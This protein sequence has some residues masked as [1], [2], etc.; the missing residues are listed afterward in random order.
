[1]RSENDNISIDFNSPGFSEDSKDLEPF[2]P[3]IN[4]YKHEDNLL[5]KL[6][7]NKS[8]KIPA[9]EAMPYK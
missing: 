2:E 1:M 5:Q 9:K 7:L 8:I 6:L 3:A 4:N